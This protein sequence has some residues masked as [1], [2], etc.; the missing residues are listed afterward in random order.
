MT[1]IDL[2]SLLRPISEDAPCGDN[3]EYDAAFGAL[4]RAAQ[5]TPERVMGDTVI[6]AA[7]PD[8]DD[9]LEPAVAL[10]DR[11]KDL[12][13]AVP[14]LHGALKTGGLPAFA[15]GLALI[16]G[17]VNDYWE[18]VHPELDKDDNDDPTLRMNSLLVLNDRAGIVA[19]LDR[20]P[21]ISS[22]TLG[23]VT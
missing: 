19:S 5:G 17:L 14:L 12:R 3:L 13:V 8:W 22:R 21:L 23:R 16:R 4:E 9:A 2:G 10:F 18:S 15:D 7:E 20:S 6:P 1:R 11:T